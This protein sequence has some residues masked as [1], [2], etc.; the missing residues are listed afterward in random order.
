MRYEASNNTSKSLIINTLYHVFYKCSN[1]SALFQTLFPEFW[2]Y[3]FLHQGTIHSVLLYIYDVRQIM[4]RS[5]NFTTTNRLKTLI[6]S[7]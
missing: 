7:S 5:N 1:C 2:K 6:I 3:F 4:G